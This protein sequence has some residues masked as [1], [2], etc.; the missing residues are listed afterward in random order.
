MVAIFYQSFFIIKNHF[1][2]S[3][4]YSRLALIIKYKKCFSIFY[5]LKRDWFQSSG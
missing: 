4:L 3:F 1:K 5:N 2:I